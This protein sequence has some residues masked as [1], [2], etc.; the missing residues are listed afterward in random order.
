MRKSRTSIP[1]VRNATVPQRGPHHESPTRP[2]HSH[3]ISH[4]RTKLVQCDCQAEGQGARS[5][6]ND[7]PS[8]IFN[9]GSLLSGN[10]VRSS[11]PVQAQHFTM[12]QCGRQSRL[13]RFRHETSTANVPSRTSTVS[14]MEAKSRHFDPVTAGQGARSI[15]NHFHL[16]R[17][18]RS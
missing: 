18:D 1:L 14:H 5:I 2:S 16:Q 10:T 6:R 4:V 15:H 12:N 9:S 17:V 8:S 13:R 11:P 7:V 3:T